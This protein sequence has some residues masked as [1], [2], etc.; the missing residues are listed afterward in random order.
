MQKSNPSKILTEIPNI[1]EFF[2]KILKEK[3]NLT[4]HEKYELL[5]KEIF[6]PT[7]TLALQL[8]EKDKKLLI[9]FL[10]IESEKSR[11]RK[12]SWKI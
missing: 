6:Q 11:L 9:F 8:V 3:M 1:Q 2:L 4:Y 10:N 5:I 12:F 7:N